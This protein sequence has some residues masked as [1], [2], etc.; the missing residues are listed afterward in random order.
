MT[1]DAKRPNFAPALEE[2]KKADDAKDKK[3]AVTASYRIAKLIHGAVSAGA[4]LAE[5]LKNVPKGAE[6]DVYDFLNLDVKAPK[7]E[8]LEAPADHDLTA[9]LLEIDVK[10]AE[11]AA[12]VDTDAPAAVEA[13]NA[14]I[15][16][17]AETTPENV[18]S[19]TGDK[20]FSTKLFGTL[21]FEFTKDDME[22]FLD[23]NGQNEYDANQQAL[24]YLEK[25]KFLYVPK[26][27]EAKYAHKLGDSFPTPTPSEKVTILEIA[28]LNFA[29]M[30]GTATD[31]LKKQKAA[32]GLLRGYAVVKGLLT[33]DV[34]ERR[35]KFDEVVFTTDVPTETNVTDFRGAFGDVSP[36]KVLPVIQKCFTSIVAIIDFYF[37]TR[38][39]H[40]LTEDDARFDSLL[41]SCLL[42]KEAESDWF[43]NS[44]I[45]HTALHPFGIARL[46]TYCSVNRAALPPAMQKRM[47]QLPAGYAHYT[48][49]RA[50]LQLL[51]PV[52]WYKRFAAAYAQSIEALNN[53]HRLVLRNPARFHQMAWLYTH[54]KLTDADKQALQHGDDAVAQL[55]PFLLAAVDQTT[56]GHSLRKQKALKKFGDMTDLMR[57]KVAEM[58][59]SW[60]R[61]RTTNI[62]DLIAPALRARADALQADE[63]AED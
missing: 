36:L 51:S 20:K 59:E 31:P 58:V 2:F 50:A 55:A 9:A 26:R 35:V 28:V 15:A 46:H 3:A 60:K 53:V 44:W 19:A 56:Q 23:M 14:Q 8:D 39:H 22:R 21:A 41:K 57:G 42:E 47:D 29:K 34:T 27:L 32:V 33:K 24:G 11:E 13:S 12:K 49:A 5:A 30:G 7:L 45:F 40:Y 43:D 6:D 63:A 4:D 37:L 17:L 18:A 16:I 61:E 52:P 10:L 38:S 48:V 25:D 62:N 1:T 54:E